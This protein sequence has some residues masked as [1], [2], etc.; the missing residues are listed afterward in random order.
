MLRKARERQ[1]IL[2]SRKFELDEEES[3]EGAIVGV[4]KIGVN[5]NVAVLDVKSLY[6]NAM[7]TCNMSPETILRSPGHCGMSVEDIENGDIPYCVVEDVYFRMDKQGFIPFVIDD[8]YELRRKYKAEM[9]SY[10]HGSEDYNRLNNMQIVCKFLLN[11]IYGV[12]K[13]KSFR[14]RDRDVFKSV[15]YFGRANNRFMQDI[16]KETGHELV[17]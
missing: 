10:E 7:K 14:L 17:L 4:C 15:T 2:P 3:V 6:P 11:S 1:V 9:H 12:S 5:K 16:V 8:L 13:Y